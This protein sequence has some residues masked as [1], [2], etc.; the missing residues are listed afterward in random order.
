MPYK[1]YSHEALALAISAV[2]RNVLSQRA[3]AAQ[4]GVPRFTFRDGVGQK[5]KGTQ[6]GQSRMLTDVEERALVTYL[7]YMA[8]QCLPHTRNI[9]RCYIRD[10][11][12]DSGRATLFNMKDGPS[13]KYFRQTFARHPDITE[14]RAETLD[15]ARKSM[16]TQQTIDDFFD[17]YGQLL[18]D[19]DLRDKMPYKTYSHEALALAISAVRRNVL[20]QRAAA[21][22]YGVPRFT[23]RDGV[24]Q[25]KKGT[26]TG[27]SRMLTDVEERALVTYLIYMANQCLPHTRNIARCYIRDIIVDSGRATLFNMKDGPS[28]KYFRQTFA[29]HPD[30]TEKRAET[31]DKARKSMS[32]QQ[33]IDDFFDLYGQLLDDYDLRDKSEQV[34]KL[35]MLFYTFQSCVCKWSHITS[36]GYISGTNFFIICVRCYMCS[37]MNPHATH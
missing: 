1:T 9:A 19:Y 14:K 33:T 4:Y 32:T 35:I 12:V 5:K 24:G 13:D 29:R 20:S 36:F 28:D 6:T 16:S 26:Q 22:Q 25:K 37:V 34:T 31:L 23:F 27:Q 3:A 10:I 18:D 8:N 30:I 2:R 7:I 11:I 15:K 21:A 17:L